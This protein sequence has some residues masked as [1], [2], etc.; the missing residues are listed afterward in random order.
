MTGKWATRC[1]LSNYQIFFLQ[2]WVIRAQFWVLVQGFERNGGGNLKEKNGKTQNGLTQRLQK[3]HLVRLSST[4]EVQSIGPRL[5]KTREN[6][7]KKSK[8]SGLRVGMVTAQK[9]RN[10]FKIS[11]VTT[12]TSEPQW[13]WGSFQHWTLDTWILRNF[14]TWL[15][16]LTVWT[17]LA[18]VSFQGKLWIPQKCHETTHQR[19]SDCTVRRSFPRT[20]SKAQ[21][22]ITLATFAWW[23]TINQPHP[24]FRL[25]WL[26]SESMT[27]RHPMPQRGIVLDSISGPIQTTMSRRIF[28]NNQ[29]CWCSK[30]AK[31]CPN[32]CQTVG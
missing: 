13:E 2:T 15:V 6:Q 25:S 23:S 5:K 22:K 28:K 12:P 19:D 26:T 18:H 30:N 24:V 16:I 8:G 27:N 10:G 32:R 17:S 20:P 11:E 3:N 7:R 1:G 9:E 4:L 31:R 14:P 21:E 29:Q